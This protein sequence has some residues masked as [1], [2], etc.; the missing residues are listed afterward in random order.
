MIQFFSQQLVAM[1]RRDTKI[2]TSLFFNG[3]KKE[4][5]GF[6]NICTLYLRLNSEEALKVDRIV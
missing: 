5:T 3:K 2:A 1:E 6:I 4:V